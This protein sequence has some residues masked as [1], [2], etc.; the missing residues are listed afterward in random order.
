MYRSIGTDLLSIHSSER[1]SVFVDANHDDSQINAIPQLRSGSV[2][3]SWVNQSIHYFITWPR[4]FLE[5]SFLR[6]D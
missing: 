4:A 5:V 6:G 2:S 1:R 3:L